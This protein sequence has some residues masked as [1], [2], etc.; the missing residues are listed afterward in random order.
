MQAVAVQ[1]NNQERHDEAD[2]EAGLVEAGQIEI[3]DG[4]LRRIA[5]REQ[6]ERDGPFSRAIARL[7]GEV[8]ADRPPTVTA[9]AEPSIDAGWTG[10]AGDLRVE[11]S[12]RSRGETPHSHP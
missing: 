12:T 8:G 3:A 4:R 11:R 9:I 7:R 1:A 5:G 6:G 2:G 10:E